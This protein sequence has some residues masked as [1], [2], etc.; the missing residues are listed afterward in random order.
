MK[1]FNE[2]R[3]KYQKLNGQSYVIDTRNYRK[4]D[5][6]VYLPACMAMCL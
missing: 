3:I 4:K 6:I 2:S 1:Y 5:D